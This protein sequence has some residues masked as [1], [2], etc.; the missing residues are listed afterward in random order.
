MSGHDGLIEII[1]LRSIEKR[2]QVEWKASLLTMLIGSQQI[3]TKMPEYEYKAEWEDFRELCSICFERNCSMTLRSCK[4]QFCHRCITR[5]FTEVVSSSW[6]LGISKITCPVC[7][8]II[9]THEWSQYVDISV[10][11]TYNKYNQPFRAC[12]RYCQVCAN[13]VPA[14]QVYHGDRERCF[15]EIAELLYSFFVIYTDDHADEEH[16]NTFLARFND[17]FR[18]HL[19]SGLPR[20]EDIYGYVSDELRRWVSVVCSIRSALMSRDVKGEEE[21]SLLRR[22]LA[23]ERECVKAAN[24]ISSRLISLE[25]HPETWTQLQFKHISSFPQASCTKCLQPLCLQCG[26]A[27]HHLSLTCSAY[28]YQQLLHAANLSSPTSSEDDLAS[29]R[30]KLE[31]SR[32]CPRCS[33]LIQR[34]DGCNKVDCLQCGHRF[35][36]VCRDAWGVKCGFYRCKSWDGVKNDSVGVVSEKPE[37]GVPNVSMLFL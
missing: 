11:E 32:T 10:V 36:W 1:C 25:Q 34:D 33:V 16:A 19:V 17:D 24:H 26:A 15:N 23:R 31:N 12:Q 18:A 7:Q 4:D 27:T 5:Y 9:P 3:V 6:G 13:V 20:V 37:L 14:A 30:W 2:R 22:G 8:D 28:L 35:C 29:L 21:P